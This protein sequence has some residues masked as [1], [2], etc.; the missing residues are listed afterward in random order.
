MRNKHVLA[1]VLLTYLLISFVPSLGLMNL[2]ARARRGRADMS[3]S[4]GSGWCS[5]ATPRCCWSWS[6]PTP[7]GR[8]SCPP[9]APPCLT[10]CPRRRA[11]RPLTSGPDRGCRVPHLEAPVHPEGEP[12]AGAANPDHPVGAVPRGGDAAGAGELYGRMGKGA[13]SGRRLVNAPVTG[14][15][16]G[17]WRV[18]SDARGARAAHPRRAPGRGSPTGPRSRMRRCSP[19]G[20]WTGAGAHARTDAFQHGHLI[21]H[22]RHII[23]NQGRATSRR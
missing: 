20:P 16:A 1:A 8:V 7:R 19:P 3:E 22:D 11:A 5:S 2:S 10:W 21:A 14:P 4:S 9:W 17:N 6:A 23:Q 15:A 12:G 18:T 13:V